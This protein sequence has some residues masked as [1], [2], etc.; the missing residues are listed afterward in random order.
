[1]S[2]ASQS[3]I[4]IQQNVSQAKAQFLELL[5]ASWQEFNEEARERLEIVQNWDTEERQRRMR[6]HEPSRL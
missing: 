3:F 6:L 2:N 4:E 1:M 5:L